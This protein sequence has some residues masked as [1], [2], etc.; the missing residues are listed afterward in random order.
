[1]FSLGGDICLMSKN[2]VIF[3]IGTFLF[4]IAHILYI[5]AFMYDISE[6]KLRK[7]KKKRHITLIAFTTFI[8]TLL[9]F[10]IN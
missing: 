1:M 4:L 5:F 8:L 3:Q 9:I 6:K 7:L 10:N 2:I